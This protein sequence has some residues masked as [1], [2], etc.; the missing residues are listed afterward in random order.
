[1]NAS[2]TSRSYFPLLLRILNS[3][4]VGIYVLTC[5]SHCQIKIDE[6]GVRHLINCMFVYM[7]E[8]EEECKK[9]FLLVDTNICKNI[10]SR[11]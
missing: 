11:I 1:M 6:G 5:F 3:A 8:K 2:I 9:T 4:W 7:E 10:M